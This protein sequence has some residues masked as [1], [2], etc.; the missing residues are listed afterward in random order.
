MVTVADITH[1]EIESSP[2]PLST[3]LEQDEQSQLTEDLPRAY[4]ELAD[5]MEKPE[6]SSTE[7]IITPSVEAPEAEP[8][9]PEAQQERRKSSRANRNV[10]DWSILSKRRL[11]IYMNNAV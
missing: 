10:W 3:Q 8:S 9:V 6:A 7:E 5:L 1:I 2:D 11:D 4:E